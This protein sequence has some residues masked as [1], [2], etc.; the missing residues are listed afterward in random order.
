MPQWENRVKWCKIQ[1]TRNSKSWIS[2]LILCVIIPLFPL[3][4]STSFIG[5]APVILWNQ[6]GGYPLSCIWRSLLCSHTELWKQVTPQP[7]HLPR[8]R[9]SSLTLGYIKDDVALPHMLNFKT[10]NNMKFPSIFL[11]GGWSSLHSFS[12][13]Q[14]V[15]MKYLNF[16]NLIF[17]L[18]QLSLLALWNEP[19]HGRAIHRANIKLLLLSFVTNYKRST[20]NPF[21]NMNETHQGYN[22]L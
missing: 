5:I 12:H 1:D 10:S 19:T 15:T 6:T 17:Q 3:S 8:Q 21:L 4:Y 18:L 22:F 13:L 14:K 9:Q 11:E 2:T 16:S 20:G 7:A